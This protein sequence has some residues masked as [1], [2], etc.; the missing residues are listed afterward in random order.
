MA[1]KKGTVLLE[2]LEGDPTVTTDAP[3]ERAPCESTLTET[4]SDLSPLDTD[5]YREMA[6]ILS[7][8]KGKRAVPTLVGFESQSAQARRYIII[9]VNNVLLEE[10]Y[11]CWKGHGGTDDELFLDNVYRITR[12]EVP[13]MFRTVAFLDL[14]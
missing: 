9:D 13:R 4:F 1:A 2:T 12:N 8:Q 5:V 11:A 6:E 7:P 14:K 3:V 10:A